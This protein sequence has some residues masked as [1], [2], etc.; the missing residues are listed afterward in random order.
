MK[1]IISGSSSGIGRA[2]TVKLL[3]LGYQVVGLAR[4]HQKFNPQSSHYYPYPL[5]FSDIAAAEKCLKIIRGDH[6]D[7]A[8]VIGNAGYGRFGML[9]Q[10]A[11]QQISELMNVNFLG[12]VLLVKTFL[13]AFKQRKAG[14][15][16]LLGSEAG[17][18][19][20]KQGSIYCASKFALRGFAQSLRQECRTAGIGVTLINPGFVNTPFFSSLNF[21][22]GPA[23]ENAMQPEDIAE[24][25]AHLLTIPSRYLIEE[26]NLQP[27]KPEICF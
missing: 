2:I 4:N 15:I 17:L 13:S 12:Q 10:F 24:T 5:D 26:I 25:V 20:A 7:I 3:S 21:T 9:E 23:P 22:P 16:I 8:A 18:A 11:M 27:L 19:G 6:P 1:V 14:K